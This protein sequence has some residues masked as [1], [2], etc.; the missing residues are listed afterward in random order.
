MKDD[1]EDAAKQAEEEKKR[2]RKKGST[3]VN[4]ASM[5]LKDEDGQYPFKNKFL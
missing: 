4:D 5:K 3:G 2:K 1:D